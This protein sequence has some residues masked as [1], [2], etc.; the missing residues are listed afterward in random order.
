M[1]VITEVESRTG[2]KLSPRDFLVGTVQQMAENL[3]DACPEPANSD[4]LNSS[5]I[6]EQPDEIVS[7]SPEPAKPVKTEAPKEDAPAS[8][9]KRLLKFWD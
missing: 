2:V 7:A 8:T 3:T 6:A 1:Q 4:D 5:A 9:V